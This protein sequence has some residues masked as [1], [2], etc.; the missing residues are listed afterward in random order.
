M[1]TILNYI[2]NLF[3]SPKKEA[4]TSCEIK[5]SS[6][7]EVISKKAKIAKKSKKKKMK[8]G[9]KTAKKNPKNKEK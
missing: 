4:L 5:D 9:T 1:K 6:I 7:P 8:E 3:T 2:K